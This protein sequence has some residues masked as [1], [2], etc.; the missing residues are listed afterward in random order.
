MQKCTPFPNE[1]CRSALLCRDRA[2]NRI[3]RKR[4]VDRWPKR[5]E[6]TNP[7]QRKGQHTSQLDSMGRSCALTAAGGRTSRRPSS[8]TAGKDRGRPD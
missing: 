5:L 4:F 7:R 8:T 1:K 2:R 6:P 3:V